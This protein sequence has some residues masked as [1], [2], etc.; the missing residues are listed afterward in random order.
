[1][2]AGVGVALVAGGDGSPSNPLA[3]RVARAT[4]LPSGG[5]NDPVRDLP[6]MATARVK[7]AWPGWTQKGYSLATPGVVVITATNARGTVGRFDI[8]IIHRTEN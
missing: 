5:T 1:M 6:G 7:A 3:V 8:P 2:A 4:V